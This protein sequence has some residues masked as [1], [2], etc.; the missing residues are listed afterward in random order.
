M[1]SDTRLASWCPV[2]SCRGRAFLKFR[3]STS[4]PPAHPGRRR[5]R[6]QSSLTAKVQMIS[7][8]EASASLC[9]KMICK[10][11]LRGDCAI[12]G[13]GRAFLQSQPLFRPQ[14]NL[15]S[16]PPLLCSD[17]PRSHSFLTPLICI[18][19][20][21]RTIRRYALQKVS[22]TPSAAATTLERR[23]GHRAAAEAADHNHNCGQAATK[24]RGCPDSHPRRSMYQHP[25]H[26]HGFTD[27][28]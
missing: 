6:L 20:R 26:L 22:S 25:L 18:A 28:R 2:P 8:G 12:D 23:H 21:Q 24:P 13:H 14:P 5:A 11:S 9:V 27:R 7:T 1:W 17:Q 15:I 10:W 4:P 3:S 16:T 19:H